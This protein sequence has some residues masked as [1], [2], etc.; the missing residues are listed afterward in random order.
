MIY[1]RY[2]L[3]P[4]CGCIFS[5]TKHNQFYCSPAC[6]DH[7]RTIIRQENKKKVII[8]KKCAFCGRQYFG[9]VSSRFCSEKCKHDYKMRCKCLKEFCSKC[10]YYIKGDAIPC[11]YIFATGKPRNPKEYYPCKEFKER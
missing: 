2:C 5:T 7:N 4:K 9:K 11:N 6:R 10:E 1:T 3:N 8:V